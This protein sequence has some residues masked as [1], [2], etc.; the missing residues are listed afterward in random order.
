[1]ILRIEARK[2]IFVN[3]ASGRKEYIELPEEQV[4][5]PKIALG[6]PKGRV[7]ANIERT[8]PTNFNI[9]RSEVDKALGDL[10]SILT[11]ARA[12]PNFKNGVPSGY[13]LFQIVPGSIYEKLG[14]MNNDTILGLDGQPVNDPGKAFELLNALKTANHLEL[15]VER[16][17]KP[18]S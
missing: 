5:N 1:R 16:D 18:V 14:L 10:N 4:L 3:T 17:G 13:K 15:Q 8:S 11:Q 12:V 2:V 9:P 6:G 7:G